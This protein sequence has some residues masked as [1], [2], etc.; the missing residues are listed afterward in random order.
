MVGTLYP[1]DKMLWCYSR[2]RN[3]DSGRLGS[4]MLVVNSL[5]DKQVLGQ[6]QEGVL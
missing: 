5:K 2:A 3:S 4:S 1:V 6:S